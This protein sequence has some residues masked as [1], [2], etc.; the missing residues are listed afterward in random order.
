MVDA[1]K[2]RIYMKNF[3]EFFND[4]VEHASAILL[5]R[6]QNMDQ[7]KLNADVSL[8]RPK[9]PKAAILTTPWE[10]L[11]G[12]QIVSAME[13]AT[14]GPR[15]DGGDRHTTTTT[16]TRTTTTS[17]AP[18]A[19]TTTITTSMS[20]STSTTT[21]MTTG[22]P[23]PAAITTPRRSWTPST[24]S[25]G[26]EGPAAP[27]WPACATAASTT[28][29]TTMATMPTR[30]SPP[31]AG[32]RLGSTAGRNFR[33]FFRPGHEEDYGYILRAKGMVPCEDG[34]T[35]LHFDLVPE[36][37]QIREGSPDYT[38]RLCVIG[39]GLDEAGL[40]KLF[41]LA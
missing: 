28:F 20:M 38:G 37:F 17:T 21:T 32:R 15:A 23:A 10:Q 18:A 30:S 24:L 12:D 19:M 22:T 26:C 40:E 4:Q 14:T 3:G 13:G 1:A 8:L 2:A 7:G 9:N 41:Q 29:T 35:W 39:S 6:T 16:T 31:G 25:M 11:T 5:S 33:T 34:Q 36:E 27:A